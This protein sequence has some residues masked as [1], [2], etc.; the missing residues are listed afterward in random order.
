[1]N[2]K[3]IIFFIGFL[4]S[5]PLTNFFENNT[6]F[7][8]LESNLIFEETFEKEEIFPKIH[9]QF[10]ENHSFE[11]VDNPFFRGGKSG[12]FELRFTDRRATKTG[13]RSELLFPVTTYKER[14]YSFAVYFPFE[15]YQDDMDNEV[16]SQWH[17]CC[18][19]PSVALRARNGKLLFRVGTDRSV[20]VS[21]WDHY[22]FGPVPKDE[23]N[24]FVFHIIHS[25]DKNGLIEIWKNGEKVVDRKGP[26]L[27][28]GAKLPAWKIGIYKSSWAKNKTLTDL[29]IIY[30]DN[31]RIG[32]EKATLEE[33]IS[34]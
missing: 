11:V 15:G 18:G 26:N 8:F 27:E 21:K 28:L 30:F 7:P 1:M 25:D 22:D 9:R 12:K 19:T 3:I 16:I 13:K 33:M 29:R 34:K 4:F 23:W 17:S 2:F 6:Y 24:E 32:S 14:W 5:Y 20:G 10:A 31:V